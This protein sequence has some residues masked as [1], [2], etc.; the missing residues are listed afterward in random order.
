MKS[1]CTL[2][3]SLIVNPSNIVIYN[4][5][6]WEPQRP[7]RKT[8]MFVNNELITVNQNFIRSTRKANGNVSDQ[9]KR[10]ITKAVDYLVTV[11]SE[12]KVYERVTGKTVKF[13]IAFVTLTLPSKQIHPDSEII[14]KCLNSFILELKKYYEVKN[15]VWRAEK[16]ENGNIHFHLIT[17]RFIPFYEL[18]NRWNRIVNKLGYVDRYQENMREFYKNGFRKSTN[19][20]D[21]RPE[22]LQYIS[23]KKASTTNFSNPNSTDIHSTKKIRNIAKYITKYITKNDQPKPDD[24]PKP[25][26]R[27]QQ[28]GRI[29]GCNHE[30]SNIQGFRSEIDSELAEDLTKIVSSGK[31]RIY[32]TAYFTVIYLNWQML[33][34]IG[35]DYMFKYFSDFLFQKF[36]YSHQLTAA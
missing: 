36:N 16:Q 35:S 19:K 29:W 20:N 27:P 13:K 2:I 9:A 17:D 1:E 6:V 8:S 10:K 26:E 3:P 31:A 15:Y 34:N 32:T 23:Y 4:Q 18:R 25:E 33:K 30:L 24:Q 22:A 11:A 28:T 21:K 7:T 12:K 14:N 5:V